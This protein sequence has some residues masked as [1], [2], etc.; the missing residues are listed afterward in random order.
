MRVR[1]PLLAQSRL[2]SFPSGTEMFHFPEYR[3][4]T[5]CIQ[6]TIREHYFTWVAP[7]GN[8]RV[9]DSL[10]L[11]EAYRSLARPSSPVRAKAFTMS[12]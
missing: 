9:K 11:T 10:H 2:I 4:V 8:P 12:T 6:I 7:F 3:F 1:S 5:L